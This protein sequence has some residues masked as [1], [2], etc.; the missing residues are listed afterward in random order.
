MLS[1][2]GPYLSLDGPQVAVGATLGLPGDIHGAPRW[3]NV[4]ETLKMLSQS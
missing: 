2:A 4:P 1:Y 3:F